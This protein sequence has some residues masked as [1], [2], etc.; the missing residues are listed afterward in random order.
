[1]M[2]GEWLGKG[3]LDFHQ[4]AIFVNKTG[5]SAGSIQ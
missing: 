1:M 3:D 5:P 4:A 2:E